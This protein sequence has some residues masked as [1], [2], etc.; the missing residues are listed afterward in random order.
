MDAYTCSTCN[1]AERDYR[2]VDRHMQKVYDAE[3]YTLPSEDTS[4][5]GPLN[6]PDP[7]IFDQ[8]DSHGIREESLSD[9]SSNDMAGEICV[10]ISQK[11]IQQFIMKVVRTKLSPGLLVST[12]EEYLR[13]MAA[14]LGDV[15]SN[16][17]E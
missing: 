4:L 7:P 9:T 12:T 13:N 2:T 16:S 5:C 3:V 10:S 17:M 15:N 8:N 6:S 14:L 1:G 11:S